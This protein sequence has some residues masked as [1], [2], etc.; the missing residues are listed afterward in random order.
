[1]DTNVDN[2]KQ[3]TMYYGF[4]P[5]SGRKRALTFMLMIMMSSIHNLSFSFG[6][7]LMLITSKR[8]AFVVF[9]GQF[10]LLHLYKLIRKDYTCWLAGTEGFMKHSASFTT[11]SIVAIVVAFCG[12]I[13][14]RGPKLMGGAMFAFI[15][16]SAQCYPF[17]ALNLYERVTK[18]KSLDSDIEEVK[19]LF[20]GLVVCWS[21]G[22]ERTKRRASER[23]SEARR[24][25]Y[26]QVVTSSTAT[27]CTSCD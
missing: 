2:R 24:Q 25:H 16:V 22:G 10:V 11:H 7:T 5:D 3:Q 21:V 17:L 6:V 14:F 1:M 4:I 20:L 19:G 23:A 26:P 18:L 15:T 9:F 8:L 13:H 27:L 12:T